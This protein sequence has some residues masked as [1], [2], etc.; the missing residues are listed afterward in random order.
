MSSLL[1]HKVAAYRSLASLLKAGATFPAALE[2]NGRS[3][4]LRSS[5]GSIQASFRSGNTVSETV[6]QHSAVFSPLES[7]VL[8]ACE[9]CGQLENAC[10]YLGSHFEL[11]Q[12]LSVQTRLQLGYP[13]FLA[14]FAILS[15]GVPTLV[16][17]GWLSFAVLVVPGFALLLAALAVLALLF[18][19]VSRGA[20]SVSLIERVLLVLPFLGPLYRDWIA[21]RFASVYALC[22][23][24]GIPILETLRLCG[25]ASQSAILE[26]ACKTASRE[27]LKGKTVGD[28]LSA[29]RILPDTLLPLWI[30]GEESGDLDRCLDHWCAISADELRSKTKAT[31]TFATRAFGILVMLGIAWRIVASAKGYFDSLNQ[32]MDF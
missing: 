27:V 13:L 6:A 23:R 18:L 20:R 4:W 7:A 15:S 21:F 26:R 8:A 1:K 5:M 2:K 3:P 14:S 19:G 25:P 16:E 30:S 9:R 10:A 17:K 31:V 12:S 28:I 32:L 22:T 24:T 11:L 29:A